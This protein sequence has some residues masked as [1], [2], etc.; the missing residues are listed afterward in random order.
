[1]KRIICI[2]ISLCL[3]MGMALA[4]QEV[5]L[6]GEHFTLSLPDGMEY[7]PKNARD[8]EQSAYFQFAYFSTKLGLEMDVFAYDNGG[9]TLSA[10]AE[11]MKEKQQDVELRRINGIDVL[12]YYGEDDP[13]TSDGAMYIGYVLM[14]GSQAVE[15]TFWYGTQQSADKAQEIMSTLQQS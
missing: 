4:D 12:T 2:C 1:M 15:I 10:L 11:A 9:V 13:A 3:L 7:S 8:A 14:D 6:P 5:K